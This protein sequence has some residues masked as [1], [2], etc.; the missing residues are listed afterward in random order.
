MTILETELRKLIN[1]ESSHFFLPVVCWGH[2]PFGSRFTMRLFPNGPWG[3]ISICKPPESCLPWD[4]REV[5]PVWY[6]ALTSVSPI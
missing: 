1:Q 3:R 5:F 6:G 2:W 4:H